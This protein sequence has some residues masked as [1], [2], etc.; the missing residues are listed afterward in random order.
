V[1]RVTAFKL[2]HPVSFVVG[3]VADDTALHVQRCV[4][5]TSVIEESARSMSTE[6]SAFQAPASRRNRISEGI[7]T[8]L[9]PTSAVIS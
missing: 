5:G 2:R 1:L 9:P 4:G 3:A 8:G 6:S 7:V